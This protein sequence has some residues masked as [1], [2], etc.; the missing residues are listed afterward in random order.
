MSV[1]LA[2]YVCSGYVGH[3]SHKHVC[4]WLYACLYYLSDTANATVAGTAFC[5]VR[6]NDQCFYLAVNA[7]A[8]L[9]S[10]LA[11]D[12]GAA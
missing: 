3:A 1:Y 6:A 5:G 2:E 11:V 10:Y 9:A 7:G 8:T 12:M 4:E